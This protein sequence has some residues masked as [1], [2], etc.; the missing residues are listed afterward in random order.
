MAERNVV[1][2]GR[3]KRPDGSECDYLA[4]AIPVLACNKCGYVEQG[5]A[6]PAP[7]PITDPRAA[8]MNLRTC[9]CGADA[10]DH[11]AL[12][13]GGFDPAWGDVREWVESLAAP[14]P[15]KPEPISSG[16]V[17]REAGAQHDCDH[18]RA[19]GIGCARC[20]PIARELAAPEPVTQDA[21]PGTDLVVIWS[22]EHHAYWRP[23]GRGYTTQL[24][25]AGIYTRADAI[26]RTAHCGP[27]KEVEIAA[28]AEIS[29]VIVEPG[30]V[31]EHFARLRSPESTRSGPGVPERM[32]PIQKGTPVP[33]SQAEIAYVTYRRLLGG[34]Q[35]LERLAER[36]GFGE[37][38]Y[39]LLRAGKNP[40]GGEQVW[41]P[42]RC[43][44]CYAPSVGPGVPVESEGT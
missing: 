6:T 32:F 41:D 16:L 42:D 26:R 24:L 22:G 40:I 43:P 15:T 21:P 31:F 5:S 17:G 14:A 34:S 12:S 44:T 2:I 27:E 38:E 13:C 3:H 39:R 30:T 11:T 37:N 8:Y 28:L 9:V 1:D 7:E 29:S 10:R 36:G 33:W 4:Y 23:E 18:W 20:N 25:G 35:T 19:E